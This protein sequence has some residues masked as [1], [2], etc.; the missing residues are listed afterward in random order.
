MGLVVQ[1]TLK[2]G[3]DTIVVDN[4][5]E[6]KLISVRGRVIKLLFTELTDKFHKINRR[7]L[8]EPRAERPRAH[9]SHDPR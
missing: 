9:E 4:E 6:I 2:P 3:M 1:R 7:E 8:N 5:L